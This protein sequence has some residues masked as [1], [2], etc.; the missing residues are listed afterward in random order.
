MLNTKVSTY[1][2]FM[3]FREKLRG[4]IPISLPSANHVKKNYAGYLIPKGWKVMPLFRNIHHNP[5]FFSAPQ[6][7]DPSRFEV[8]AAFHR[9]RVFFFF[10]FFALTR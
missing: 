10:P 2:Q 5:E 4:F 8:G 3:S 9:N 6:N 7:F 1:S